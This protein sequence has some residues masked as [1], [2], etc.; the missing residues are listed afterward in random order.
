M[1]YI[2]LQTLYYQSMV[3]AM[4]GLFLGA[5]LFLVIRRMLRNKKVFRLLSIAVLIIPFSIMAISM[6]ILDYV[7]H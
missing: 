7:R 5:L 1:D 2:Q 3:Q 6:S 4:S